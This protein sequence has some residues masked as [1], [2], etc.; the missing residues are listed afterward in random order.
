VAAVVRTPG[1]GETITERDERT[2]RILDDRDELTVTETRYV[3]GEHGPEPHIHREHVDAFWVLAGELAFTLGR[4]DAVRAGAGA[5]VLVPPEVV[6]T[7]WN[8]APEEARFLNLHVPD[9]GFAESLRARRDEREPVVPFDSFDPPVDGGRPSSE[10]LV[11]RSGEGET[12][13]VGSSHLT[14]KAIGEK[15]GGRVFLSESAVVPGF[16]GPPPH[17]HHTLHDVFYV[18]EGMLTLRLGDEAHEAPPGTFAC[19]PPGAVHTFANRSSEPV[20][21]LNFN[22]P[23]GF[24]GYMRDLAAAFA[25]AGGPP[26]PEEIGRI[27]SRYD[28]EAA[29]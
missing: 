2:I 23:S 9:C 28:Y 5:F 11:L 26:T 1:G 19:I 14:L 6:H 25:G 15:T 13:F 12:L 21:F 29:F 22:T 4:D 24:E 27:V 17:V 10:A 18:L 8:E 16:P 3:T 7:F 20:R